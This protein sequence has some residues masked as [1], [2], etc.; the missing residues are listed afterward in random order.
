MAHWH[1][2]GHAL[3]TSLPERK[4]PPHPPAVVQSPEEDPWLG[5]HAHLYGQPWKMVVVGGSMLNRFYPGSGHSPATTEVGYSNPLAP[6][7]TDLGR[8]RRKQSPKEEV[9]SPTC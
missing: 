3:P 8:G 7:A 5:L 6:P 4:A 9:I 1:L 2:S